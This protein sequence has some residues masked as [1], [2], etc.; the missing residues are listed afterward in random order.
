MPSL[1][2]KIELLAPAGN[3]EKLETAIHYGAG[4]VY[5][6]GKDFSLRNFS[7]NFSI[8]EMFKAVSYAHSK[9][10]KVYVAC[11]IYP[12]TDEEAAISDFLSALSEIQPDAVIIAD[13]GVLMQAKKI[14]PDIDV[15]L[16]T[17]ANTTSRQS[18]LFWAS[19]G[20]TRIN[21]A[22]ELTLDEIKQIARNSPVEVESFV[23][24]AMCISYSGRCL[25]SSYMARRDSNRGM[26]AH[27]CRWKY[28]VV[29][30]LRPGHYMPLAEDDRGSYIFNSRDLCMIEHIPEMIRAGISSLKIEGRMKGINYLAAAIKTYRQAIDF[31]YEAPEKYTVS[32]DWQQTLAGINQRGYCTGFY[33]NDPDAI[34]PN[35]E[36]DKPQNNPK[37][38][39][40][41][42]TAINPTRFYVGVRNKIQTDDIIEILTAKGPNQ[43][44][45]IAK[46][47]SEN[48]AEMPVAQ[49]NACV[50]IETE[51]PSN[52][53]PNDIIQKTNTEI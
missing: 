7:G 3:F 4:A 53:E 34:L 44:N 21:T 22:R 26:C 29:E 23:H 27:P 15:H 1:K 18:V 45:R 38:V 40:K 8:D 25:L 11:N 46:I 47:I 52:A 6:A 2:Q 20:V 13:P 14:I 35:Y 37:F 41:I 33:L 19:Q 16:S 24:G 28:S 10:V 9:G 43:S 36:K 31:Y 12:R 49:P 51:F 32:K 48:N 17:Q 5:L 42:A 50:F 39:G 30:E